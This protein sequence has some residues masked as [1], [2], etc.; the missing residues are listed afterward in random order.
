MKTK[1]LLGASAAAFVLAGVSITSMQQPQ[2]E[3]AAPFLHPLMI[4][5]SLCGENVDGL[6]KRRAF[7]IRAARAY[8]QTA[9]G[10]APAAPM[11]APNL[12]ENIAYEI[13]TSKPGSAGVVQPGR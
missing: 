12:S 6:A 1:L 4:A 13:T 3:Q 9:A 7:F 8:A 5:R 11:L 2:S 10:D